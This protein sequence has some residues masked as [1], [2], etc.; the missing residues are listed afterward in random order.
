MVC[1][2]DV[3][4]CCVCVGKWR[5]VYVGACVYVLCWSR[6]PPKKAGGVG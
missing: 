5:Y 1:M 6:N 4:V 3:Y 2:C